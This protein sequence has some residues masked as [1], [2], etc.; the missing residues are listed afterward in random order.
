MPER[1]YPDRWLNHDVPPFAYIPFGAGIHTC[2]GANF[3]MMA[4]KLAITMV[5]QRYRLH[6]VSGAQI[7]R[8]LPRFVLSSK[9]GMPMTV[10]TRQEK[11]PEPNRPQGNIREMVEFLRL[12]PINLKHNRRR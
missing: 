6:L 2:I 7:D 11:E 4:M 12:T 3:A 8:Y 10:H 1:F 5:V 9:Q